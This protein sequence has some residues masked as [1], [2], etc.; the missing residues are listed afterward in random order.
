MLIPKVRVITERLEKR[1]PKRDW[2]YSAPCQLPCDCTHKFLNDNNVLED[3]VLV[4]A[5]NEVQELVV[6]L[7]LVFLAI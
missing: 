4:V 3:F 7:E 5:V 2:F 6:E 1:G